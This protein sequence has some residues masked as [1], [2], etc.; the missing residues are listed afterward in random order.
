MLAEIVGTQPMDFFI[1]GRLVAYRIIGKPLVKWTFKIFWSPTC[2][3]I[4][5]HHSFLELQKVSLPPIRTLLAT[6]PLIQAHNGINLIN[7]GLQSE[8]IIV[9]NQIHRQK[10]KI[11]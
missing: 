11:A 4:R 1:Y 7:H 3:K 10:D 8:N 5:Y 2:S 9:R 6:I